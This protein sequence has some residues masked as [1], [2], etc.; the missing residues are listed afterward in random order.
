MT[1]SEVPTDTLPAE[2]EVGVVDIGPFTLENGAVI[3]D[4]SIA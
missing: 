4:V 3:D 2:G 1:I